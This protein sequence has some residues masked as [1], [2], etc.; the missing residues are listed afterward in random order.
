[1]E[2]NHFPALSRRRPSSS[3]G[4]V[5]GADG[6]RD[7]LCAAWEITESGFGWLVKAAGLSAG[8]LYFFCMRGRTGMTVA[9]DCI[10]FIPSA[11]M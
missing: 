2:E 9:G 8:A 4:A 10:T 1:M 3:G 11:Q 6:F 7:F 5:R